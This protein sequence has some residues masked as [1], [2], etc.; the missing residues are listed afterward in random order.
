VANEVKWRRLTITALL[1]LVVGGIISETLHSVQGV[2]A[3]PSGEPSETTDGSQERECPPYL[4]LEPPGRTPEPFAP[5]LLN[6]Y[7]LHGAPVFSPDG[8]RVCW[9]VLPPAILS[10]HCEDGA[11][12]KPEVLPLPGVAVQ[13]P[14][15]SADGSR[16]YYQAAGPGSTGSLDLWWVDAQREDWENAS[17]LGSP[18]NSPELESQPTLTGEG[19]L[20]FTGSM[21]G[22]QFGR[23]IFRAAPANG[24]YSPPQALGKAINTPGI[25]YC[26]FVT[27]DGG[28]LLF[29]SN[30]GHTGEKLFI[31]IALRTQ[32]GG[33]S[34]PISIHPLMKHPQPARFPWV[35]PDG[36]FLFFLSQGQIWWVD[37][38]VLESRGEP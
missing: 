20:Y 24:G 19:E 17:N 36:R 9:S 35:S 10:M 32:S 5:D 26:P 1:L 14:A 30:R 2:P 34:E 29:A 33:W 16:L 28:T 6:E 37:A 23:G 4:G 3:S 38:D 8:Q 7:R 21:N 25:D 27:V 12:T 13:A 18:V 15:F 11:W 31:H 22:V